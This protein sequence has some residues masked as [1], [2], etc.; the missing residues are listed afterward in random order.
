M[1]YRITLRSNPRLLLLFTVMTS[2]PVTGIVLLAL[3][4]ITLGLIVT[5]VGI[6]F[7]YQMLKLVRSTL[8]SR[9]VTSEESIN[10]DFGKGDAHE[11]S[12]SAVTHSG[13]FGKTSRSRTV[14]VY[15]EEGDRLLSVPDEYE[16]FEALVEEIEAP[17]GPVF[18]TIDLATETSISD[19]LR[20][21]VGGSNPA[22]DETKS[23]GS[24]A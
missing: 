1:T 22:E 4:L 13:T 17:T 9:V 15:A 14:F 23:D 5:I 18:E 16:G 20:E 24:D 11:I 10:Y 2:V 8:R 19:Y 6:Y 3:Q 7:A 12:W 21:R